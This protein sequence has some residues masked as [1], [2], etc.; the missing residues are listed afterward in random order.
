M[1]LQGKYSFLLLEGPKSFHF[2]FCNFQQLNQKY[3]LIRPE[4]GFETVLDMQII[5]F[6]KRVSCNVSSTLKPNVSFKSL[7]TL[8]NLLCAWGPHLL[9]MFMYRALIPVGW[10]VTLYIRQRLLLVWCLGDAFT[11]KY[12]KINV[13]LV[14]HYLLSQGL[15]F[16]PAF[17]ICVFMLWQLPFLPSVPLNTNFSSAQMKH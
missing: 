11:W 12:N 10:A 5:L 1:I 13:N 3:C 7:S 2:Y 9:V 16:Y 17:I 14:L 4:S 8:W 15:W 6:P